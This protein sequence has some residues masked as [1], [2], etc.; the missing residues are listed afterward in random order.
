VSKE[1]WLRKTKRGAHRTYIPGDPGL[2]AQIDQVLKRTGFK[3]FPNEGKGAATEEK[4]ADKFKITL[5]KV[6]NKDKAS[7]YAGLDKDVKVIK[8]PANATAI[9]T[10]DKIPIAD[11]D[12][13]LDGWVTGGGAGNVVGP[14]SAIDSNLAS[15][16]GTSGKLIKDSGKATIDIHNKQHSIISTDDHTSTATPGKVLKADA[17]GLPVDATNTDTDVADAVSKKHTQNTDTDLDATFEATFVKKADNVNVLADITSPG[18]DIEDAVTKKHTQGTDTTLGTMTADVAMG[19][20]KL[21]GLS[22]P[23]SNGDSIRATTKITEANLEDAVDKKHTATL[24]GTKTLDETNIN[25]NWLIKYDKANDKLVYG[26]VAGI[27]R[28][29]AHYQEIT[30]WSD[31]LPTAIVYYTDSGKT[32]KFL[33]I[34]PTYNDSGY[35][36]SV[37]S[38]VYKYD[39][40]TV[41]L[42]MTD[43]YNYNANN[44]LLN[45]TRGVS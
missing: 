30:S 12:G 29:K 37:I 25:D 1:T 32:K 18:A 4:I 33:E 6:A 44:Q 34:I 39:G 27:I 9:P 45:K 7:G 2:A 8:N 10:A 14:D 22:V 41:A 40:S 20:H 3:N 35:P 13:K 26:I 36:T 17:N 15:F 19:T 21:T 24:L 5:E 43:S 11:G 28:D 31:D 16:D 23:A 42:T 38:K